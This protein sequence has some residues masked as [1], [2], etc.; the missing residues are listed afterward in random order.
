MHVC[1]QACQYTCTMCVHVP[2]NMLV[3]MCVHEQQS[4][5]GCLWPIYRYMC[6]CVTKYASVHAY[7]Y[8]QE[9]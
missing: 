1:E 9:C 7:V 8:I 5:D 3:C 2:W 4:T 6:M